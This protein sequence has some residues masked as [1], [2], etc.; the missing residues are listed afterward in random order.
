MRIKRSKQAKKKRKKILK[1]NKGYLGIRK[2][3]YKKAKEAYI[4]AGKYAY[5]DRK[6]KKRRNRSLWQIRIGN[7][8]RKEELSYSRFIYLLKENKIELDR[9][10]LS[11]LALNYPENFS[12]LV[13]KVKK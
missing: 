5:R 4:K 9:K 3:C 10:I 1:A 11:T 2:S 8:V 7:A 12:A 6:V 13:K